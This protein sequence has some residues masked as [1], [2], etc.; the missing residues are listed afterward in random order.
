MGR[1]GRR[2]VEADASGRE[3]DDV[4]AGPDRVDLPGKEDIS[5][6]SW[7]AAKV[8]LLGVA[9]SLAV[10]IPDSSVSPHVDRSVLSLALCNDSRGGSAVKRFER[11]PTRARGVVFEGEGLALDAGE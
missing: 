9:P 3:S 4:F 2:D 8:E 1:G 7:A 6:A 10:D 11:L 5:L